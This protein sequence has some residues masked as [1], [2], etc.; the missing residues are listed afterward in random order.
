[1]DLKNELAPY[2]CG[3]RIAGKYQLVKPIGAGGMGIVWV[4]HNLVLD[5]HVALKLIRGSIAG[6]GA[7]DRLLREARSA[8]RLA[9]PG[10]VR[11]F[12]FGTSE[13]GDPFI[14]MEL[15][16]GETLRD[17]LDR[18]GRLPPLRAA[19]LLLPIADALGALADGGIVHRDLKPD[20]VLLAPREEGRIQPILVDF[21]VAILSGAQRLTWG[22]LLVGTP[23]YIAPEQADGGEVDH[24]VDVWAFSVMLFEALTG[25]RP[26]G[27]KTVAELLTNILERPAPTIESLGVQEPELS[28]IVARGLEKALRARW[29]SIRALRSELAAWAHAQGLGEDVTG[30]V[31]HGRSSDAGSLRPQVRSVSSASSAPAVSGDAKTEI[32]PKPRRRAPAPAPPPASPVQ[33]SQPELLARERARAAAAD[34]ETSP[35]TLSR[36]PSPA[37]ETAAPETARSRSE[38]VVPDDAALRGANRWFRGAVIGLAVSLALAFAVLLVRQR[39]TAMSAEQGPSAADTV[40]SGASQN[41][42]MPITA[43]AVAPVTTAPAAVTASASASPAS[44]PPPPPRPLRAPLGVPVLGVPAPRPPAPALPSDLKDPYSR[45]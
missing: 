1:L 33:E 24:R 39:S 28:A 42:A 13:R 17:L 4:A 8:A 19:S 31:V 32:A 26:F 15:L 22:N 23:D 29:P 20:N 9:H 25:E 18:E 21:G 40:P 2:A 36:S 27:G 34:T 43:S 12:D 41:T 37:P 35:A 16:S 45:K 11:V 10:V 14:V 38:E 5:V 6:P 44:Q 30:A 3:D 7:A